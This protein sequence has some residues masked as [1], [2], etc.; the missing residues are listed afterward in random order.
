MDGQ[1]VMITGATNGLGKETA[2]EIARMGATVILVGRNEDK[3]QRVV[4]DIQRETGNQNVEYMIAD[5]AVMD[6]IRQLAETFK[7][8]YDQLHVLINNAGMLFTDRELT[9]D[10]YER[11]FALNHLNYFLLT[12]LLL[13]T[14]KATGTPE[15]N[16][17]IV[18]VSS[19]AHRM[20][21]IDFDNLN[22]E[23]SYNAMSAYGT[24]KLENVLFT[25]ELARRLQADGANV[26][27]NCLHPGVVNT[28]FGKNN[29]GF[30]GVVAK[31]FM[32]LMRPFQI[33]ADQGAQTQIYLATSPEVEGVTGKYFENQKPKQSNKASY[34]EA[35]Q[36]QLWEISEEMTGLKQAVATA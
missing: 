36:R 28:G 4:A 30:S 2:L 24:S 27:A 3:A 18:N 1:I 14:L 21:K 25:Y 22:G 20:G 23:K 8:K 7:A 16:A 34:D 5:L 33:S 10:G 9:A 26:T 29:D 6:D 13:E 17:R 31:F 11:T 32:L 19:S 35:A 15:H 12:N